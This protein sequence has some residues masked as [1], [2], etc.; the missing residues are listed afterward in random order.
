M[1]LVEIVE[2]YIIIDGY[3]YRF[4][5]KAS[6]SGDDLLTK[7]QTYEG[8]TFYIDEPKVTGGLGR[9]PNPIEMFLSSL[10]GCFIV[11]LRLHS[12]RFK[13]PVNSVEVL[14]DGSFDIRGFIMPQK[15]RSGFTSLSLKIRVNSTANC[16][17]LSRLLER[18]TR[19]WVVGSTIS[20]ALPVKLNLSITCL[21]EGNV[22]E[23][24]FT[25]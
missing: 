8:H 21:D 2:P 17:D 3:E 4:S 10:A 15:F 24:S 22:K 7:V 14:A 16:D 9:A 13:I 12:T 1:N 6:S 25:E 18:V 19:G 5:V 20:N 11:T 23:L